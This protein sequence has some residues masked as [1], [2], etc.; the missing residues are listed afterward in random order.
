MLRRIERRL[1]RF[2]GREGWKQPAEGVTHPGAWGPTWGMWLYSVVRSRQEV[3][4]WKLTANI[5]EA[6]NFAFVLLHVPQ[7]LSAHLLL[8]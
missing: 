1:C 4:P 6:F 2:D 7:P 3:Q 5:S 8:L